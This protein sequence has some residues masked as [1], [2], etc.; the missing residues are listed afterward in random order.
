MAQ[1]IK[2]K[3]ILEAAKKRFSHFGVAKTTMNEIA[4]DL[5]MSK[6]SLYYYFPDKLNLYAA[7]LLDIIETDESI[8]SKYANGKDPETAISDY[9]DSRI[10]FINK[11]YNILEY[12]QT[13]NLKSAKELQ[14]V[15]NLVRDRQLRSVTEILE[16]GSQSGK[17]KLTNVKRQAELLLDCLEGLRTIMLARESD[18]FPSKKVL[19]NLVK[20]EKE[21]AAIYVR[22]LSV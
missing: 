20:R 15:F 4:D 12:L 14:S 9:L 3:A 6:A 19:Q 18:F 8:N 16:L 17:L 5:A 1:D 13:P 10:A 7:V 22:G 11:Y 21:L 2:K